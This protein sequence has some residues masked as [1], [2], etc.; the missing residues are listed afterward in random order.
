MA[1]GWTIRN[2]ASVTVYGRMPYTEA[3]HDRNR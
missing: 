1:T 3:R 2:V